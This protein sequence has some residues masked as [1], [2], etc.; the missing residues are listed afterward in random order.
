M[1]DRPK[2]QVTMNAI[3][4]ASL[5]LAGVVVVNADTVRLVSGKNL[6]GQVTGYTNSQFFLESTNHVIIRVP[7]AA[8]QTIDFESA[9]AESVLEATDHSS[10]KGK[11]S[12]Y[13]KGML[14]VEDDGGQVDRVPLKT[15]FTA[16]FGSGAAPD[17]PAA[18]TPG[19]AAT[20]PAAKAE[21]KKVTAVKI[22]QV[23]D[24]PID[25]HLVH[26]KV[27]IVDFY[28]DWCG[29]CRSIGPYLEEL[30]T[31]DDSVFLRKVNVDK[32]QQLSADFGI[33]AIP[34]IV[35]YDRSGK[36]V[37]TIRGANR[38]GVDQ[39]VAKAKESAAD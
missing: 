9:S 25:K 36:N 4:T 37:G 6:D 26:G 21:P 27:T 39:M 30:A 22:E 1:E 14:S 5:I 18:A 19:T 38:E 12:L 8:V 24:S 3:L 32:N 11:I 29:P 16:N 20:A 28:A 35:I 7:A 15:I 10:L 13:S 34:N 23:S 33:R 31:K 17:A 2:A